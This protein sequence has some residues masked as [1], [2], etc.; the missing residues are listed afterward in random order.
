MTAATTIRIGTLN[1]LHTPYYEKYCDAFILTEDDRLADRA[2]IAAE[3]REMSVLAVQE[4][5]RTGRI[6][7]FIKGAMP[8]CDLLAGFDG[9]EGPAILYDREMFGVREWKFYALRD[10][11]GH[12]GCKGYTVAV[13]LNRETGA[14]V[15]TVASC[16]VPYGRTARFLST[17]LTAMVKQVL[18][19]S[20]GGPVLIAG[21]FNME[22]H[23]SLGGTVL[24]AAFVPGD[25]KNLL[26][27]LPFTSR[28]PSDADGRIDY[29][30]YRRGSTQPLRHAGFAGQYPTSHEHLLPHMAGCTAAAPAFLSDHA[31]CWADVLIS[32]TRPSR[33]PAPAPLLG[34]TDGSSRVLRRSALNR[35]NRAGEAEAMGPAAILRGEKRKRGVPPIRARDPEHLRIGTLNLLHTPY[36]ETYCDAFILTEDDRLAD[37][38]RIAAEL[39]EMS[40]LAVQECSRTGRITEFIKGA[41]PHCDL[42]AGFDGQEGPAILYDREVFSVVGE[43]A[44]YPL[45]DASGSI[46][47]KGFAAVVLQDRQ[48]R[49]LQVTLVSCQCPYSK[50]AGYSMAMLQEIVDCAAALSR[51]SPIL[52]A[53]EL[54]IDGLLNRSKTILDAA[55]PPSAWENWLQRAPFTKRSPHDVAERGDYLYYRRGSTQLLRHDGAAGQYPTSYEH[56]V[57][58]M[59]GC[60]AAAPAF[61]SDH[62]LCWA[63][64]SFV[65]VSLHGV[66]RVVVQP[67][68]IRIGTLNLMHTPYYEKLCRTDVLTEDERLADRARITAELREM[69]VLAVQEYSPDSGISKFLRDALPRHSVSACV[70][71]VK[72]PVVFY[73]KCRFV[74]MEEAFV[75]LTGFEQDGGSG[76][77]MLTMLK[78]TRTGVV[79]SVASVNLAFVKRVEGRLGINAYGA[80]AYDAKSRGWR[81]R[82]RWVLLPGWGV[83]CS[84]GCCRIPHLPV[85]RLER[86]ASR[87]LHTSHYHRFN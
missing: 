77:Y 75:P 42:L 36:Y 76:G 8:H 31:L 70:A 50:D 74:R 43:C 30:Y 58:H 85:T 59:A 34:P 72:G 3:L 40:V 63:D 21:D 67:T 65:D 53:G 1:L 2:R 29:I 69:S 33:T 12:A 16:H 71:V 26:D 5:S 47:P 64:M 13:L 10:E 37:R 14:P 17:V 73:D 87:W 25:W 82:C 54:N 20:D 44:F 46:R 48:R 27:G 83:Q 80:F 38:A 51:G 4:C 41:M 79:V 62:A 68:T 78:D 49:E 56:L 86:S 61:L 39:R 45:P 55:F 32:E 24:G 6:T 52:I 81:S 7:E 19:H 18:Q 35:S 57:P 15:L 66:R 22:R 84:T 11:S 28:T 9:Q 23:S 60:T